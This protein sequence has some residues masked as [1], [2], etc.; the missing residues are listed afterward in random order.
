SCQA[1]RNNLN[2]RSKNRVNRLSGR[3]MSKFVSFLYRLARISN[4][5]E[6]I[7]SGNPKKIARRAKNKILGRKVA[8]KI[9][10][11]PKF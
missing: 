1:D 11:W 6:T 2:K 4:D 3:I 5:I 7:A 8:S 10:K 9:Y